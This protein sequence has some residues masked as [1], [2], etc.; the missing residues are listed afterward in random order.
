MIRE[1]RKQKKWKFI[2]QMFMII[3][4]SLS[5]G[6]SIIYYSINSSL[7]DN[8][9]IYN[10]NDNNYGED[11]IFMKIIRFLLFIISIITYI[12]W[13]IARL[14]LGISLTYKIQSNGPLIIKGLYSKF[15]HPI[16]YFGTI[17]LIAFFFSI[18]ELSFYRLLF[19]LFFLIPIQII[20]GVLEERVLRK[21]YDDEYENYI[22]Q[23]WI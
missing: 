4:Q 20:R 23:L 13:F 6:C 19:I 2:Y 17:S 18:K 21:K 22:K 12:L 7:I 5:V 3:I 9:K 16:Y 14:Q 10:K 8:T 15:K 11:N 1:E